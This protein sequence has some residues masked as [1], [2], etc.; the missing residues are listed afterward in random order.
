MRPSQRSQSSGPLGRRSSAPGTA[1]PPS[2]R[3]VSAAGRRSG[4]RDSS[5]TREVRCACQ[6]FQSESLLPE[7]LSLVGSPP[8]TRPPS[9]PGSAWGSPVANWRATMG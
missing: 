3:E 5:G 9:R 2:T 1:A 6:Y 7:R 8:G 4:S